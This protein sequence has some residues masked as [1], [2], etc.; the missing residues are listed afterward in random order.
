MPDRTHQRKRKKHRECVELP[1]EN[2]EVQRSGDR[3]TEIDKEGCAENAGLE[4][5]LQNLGVWRKGRGVCHLAAIAD[6]SMF[7]KD[8]IVLRLQ[9][10][11]VGLRAVT[12]PWRIR[13]RICR[14]DQ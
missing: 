5:G 3:E 2:A 12:K 6:A 13:D 4:P 7:R 10:E 1:P 14:G 9:R 8:R 11:V